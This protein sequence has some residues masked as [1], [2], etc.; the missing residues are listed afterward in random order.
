VTRRAYIVSVGVNA[1]QV[2]KWKLKYAANDAR[3]M[4]KVVAEQLKSANQ[5]EVVSVLLLADDEMRNGK[6]VEVRDATKAQVHAVLDLLAGKPVAAEL[7]RS[8]P[9]NEELKQ[10][11]PDDLVLL[12]FSS[13]GYADQSGEFFILPYDVRNA[14]DSQQQIPEL[15]SCISS[16]ELSLWLRDVDAGEMV[17]IVDACHAAKIVEGSGFKPGPM[18]SR[19]LGQLSYDKAMRILTATQAKDAAVEVGGNIRQGLL[20]YA[21]L[22]EGL[23]QQ[24]A[25]F[26]PVDKQITLREWLNY[27]VVEV[28]EIYKRILSGELE[29]IGRDVLRDEK[30]QASGYQ[31]VPSLFDFARKRADVTLS[32]VQA[33][34]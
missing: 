18:G 10:A 6:H 21:L 15:E 19:G 14:A 26:K 30:S 22:K 3:L 31:Q 2:E 29:S 11:T 17:M 7:R 25:N 5:Y 28:P 13:H 27:G 4:N 1:S 12:S 33:A 34:P 24:R 23:E 32:N 20:S 8:I 16:E 9:N